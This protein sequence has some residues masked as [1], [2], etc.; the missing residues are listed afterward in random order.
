MSGQEDSSVVTVTNGH[1][2]RINNVYLGEASHPDLLSP[3]AHHPVMIMRIDFFSLFAPDE[4]MTADYAIQWLDLA[5]LAGQAQWFRDRLPDDKRAHW[6]Q[7]VCD[8]RNLPG[9][10]KW[11]E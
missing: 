3:R 1:V 2:G 4:P 6:D 10:E 9:P 11:G 8:T 7:I 5:L